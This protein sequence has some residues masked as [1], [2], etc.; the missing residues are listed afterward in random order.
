MPCIIASTVLAPFSPNALQRKTWGIEEVKTK[1]LRDPESTTA[2]SS[3]CA[4]GRGSVKR[5]VIILAMPDNVISV[6]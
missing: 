6:L 3:H 2:P 5:N 4:S 1:N